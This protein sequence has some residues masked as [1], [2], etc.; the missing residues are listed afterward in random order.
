MSNAKFS[1]LTSIP[2]LFSGYSSLE[3]VDLSGA[4]FSNTTSIQYFSHH[5]II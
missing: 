4:D 3:T 2:I 5:V 1:S